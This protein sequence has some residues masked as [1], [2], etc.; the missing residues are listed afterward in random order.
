MFHQLQDPKMWPIPDNLYL[1]SCLLNVI[2]KEDTSEIWKI[3]LETWNI[4][5]VTIPGYKNVTNF[6]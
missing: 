2:Q 6:P 5:D 4:N 3:D 1:Y